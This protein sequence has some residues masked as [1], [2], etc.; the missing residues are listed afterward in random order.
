MEKPAAKRQRVEISVAI[1]KAIVEEKSKN[2]AVTQ[3]DLIQFAKTKFDIV[4]GRSTVSDILKTKD[5]WIS[6]TEDAATRKKTA[7]HQDLDAALALWFADARRRNI[8]V[9]GDILT[10]K[11]K[12]L[13]EKLGIDSD[14]KYSSGWLT[15]FKQRHNI[16]N[17]VIHSECG[18]SRRLI[19]DYSQTYTTAWVSFKILQS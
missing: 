14:F 16:K 12:E 15:R 4:I 8:I 9:N 2:P 11:A 1:K 17:F 7:K 13:G 5:R 6:S 18:G 3:Q 19:A 10:L